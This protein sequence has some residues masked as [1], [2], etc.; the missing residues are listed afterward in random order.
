MP[1]SGFL[2]CALTAAIS[3]SFAIMKVRLRPDC[4]AVL[5]NYRDQ[6]C[7]TLM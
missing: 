1:A 3:P 6:L 5:Q 7:K 2:I 4:L